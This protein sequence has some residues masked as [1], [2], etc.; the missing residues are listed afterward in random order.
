MVFVD[1]WASAKSIILENQRCLLSLGVKMAGGT[2]IVQYSLEHLCSIDF[3]LRREH[4][5]ATF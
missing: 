3:F 5:Q 2:R 4:T 1:Q